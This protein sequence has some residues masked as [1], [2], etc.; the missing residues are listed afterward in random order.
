MLRKYPERFYEVCGRVVRLTDPTKEYNSFFLINRD[1]H[2]YMFK[3]ERWP[4]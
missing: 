4:T 3:L 2:G 1:I